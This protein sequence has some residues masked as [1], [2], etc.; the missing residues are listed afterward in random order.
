M[1]GGVIDS[2]FFMLRAWVLIEFF[3]VFMQKPHLMH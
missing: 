3:E 1:G 2:M